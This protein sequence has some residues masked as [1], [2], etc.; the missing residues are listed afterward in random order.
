MRHNDLIRRFAITIIY[1]ASLIKPFINSTYEQK[2]QAH[3]NPGVSE[4]ASH[5]TNSIHDKRACY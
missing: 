5:Q 2:K 3:G 1:R 4:L